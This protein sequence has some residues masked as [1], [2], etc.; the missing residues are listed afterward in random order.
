MADTGGAGPQLCHPGPALIPA[1]LAKLFPS[2]P[3]KVLPSFRQ[4]LSSAVIGRRTLTV[5]V[6]RRLF[7]SLFIHSFFPP[8]PSRTLKDKSNLEVRAGPPLGVAAA[9]YGNAAGAPGPLCVATLQPVVYH[10]YEKF[11]K[12]SKTK[13][14]VL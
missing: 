2:A 6:F 9:P 4:P 11:M 7:P 5:L 14:Q 8:F 3:P 1:G 10:D 12:L 13:I